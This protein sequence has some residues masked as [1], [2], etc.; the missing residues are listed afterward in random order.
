MTR[1]E[2]SK[3]SIACA[4]KRSTSTLEYLAETLAF[5]LVDTQ[6]ILHRKSAP[7][8]CPDTP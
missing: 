4:D 1:L 2:S 7:D 6:F 3:P 5:R 8:A